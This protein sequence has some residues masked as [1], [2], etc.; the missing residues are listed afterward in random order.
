MMRIRREVLRSGRAGRRPGAVAGHRP[1]VRLLAAAHRRAADRG[2]PAGPRDGV[3][4]VVPP[5]VGR[6]RLERPPV[7]ILVEPDDGAHR[8]AADAAPARVAGRAGG[9]ARV[10]LSR[11]AVG[12]G[13]RHSPRRRA[14]TR[15]GTLFDPRHDAGP[16]RTV[17]REPELIDATLTV[18]GETLGQALLPWAVGTAAAF[19]GGIGLATWAAWH[20]HVRHAGVPRG[21]RRAR[22]DLPRTRPA[23]APADAVSP[24][25]A[26]STATDRRRGPG[27]G[28]RRS[29]CGG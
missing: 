7:R 25:R 23:P 29:G 24:A 22:P 21:A 4:A 11:R 12:R 1:A 26:A 13:D 6:A 9:G 10:R 15:S 18:A 17:E 16:F 14:S 19:L 28:S 20:Y 5:G 8:G 27:T 2:Q 3:V